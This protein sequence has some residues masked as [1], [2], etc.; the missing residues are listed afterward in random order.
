MTALAVIQGPSANYELAQ[1]YEQRHPFGVA[2]EGA[3]APSRNLFIVTFS[4]KTSR[5][6]EKFLQNRNNRY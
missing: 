4:K 1:G 6:T 2:R 3:K 5:F